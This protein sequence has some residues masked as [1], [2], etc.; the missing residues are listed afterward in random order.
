MLEIEADKQKQLF[1]VFYL[2]THDMQ[3]YTYTSKSTVMSLYT[4]IR[5]V[6]PFVTPENVGA[7]IKC[8]KR[9]ENV[10]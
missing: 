2:L 7:I 10:Q 5:Q 6:K 8:S 1:C 9:E 4:K 3:I